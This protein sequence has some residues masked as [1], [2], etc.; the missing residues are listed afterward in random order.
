MMPLT[1]K[2][3][4]GSC[5]IKKAIL[6]LFLIELLHFVEK[7]LTTFSKSCHNSSPPTEKSFVKIK[8]SHFEKEAWMILI[9]KESLQQEPALVKE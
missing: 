6:V 4:C 3:R 1:P 8:I 2:R 7:S 5:T 9:T